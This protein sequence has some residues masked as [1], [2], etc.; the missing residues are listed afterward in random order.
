MRLGWPGHVG[1]TCPQQ[2]L[3]IYESLHRLHLSENTHARLLIPLHIALLKLLCHRPKGAAQLPVF[4]RFHLKGSWSAE[5]YW[6]RSALSGHTLHRPRSNLTI[7]NPF[8]LIPRLHSRDSARHQL[9]KLS[10]VYPPLSAHPCAVPRRSSEG[11][12]ATSFDNNRQPLIRLPICAAGLGGTCLYLSNAEAILDA[13]LRGR[14][15]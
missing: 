3:W 12:Q 6:L 10:V 7:G 11:V 1:R 5:T 2:A 8:H 4:G 9:H 13:A 15:L 14:F